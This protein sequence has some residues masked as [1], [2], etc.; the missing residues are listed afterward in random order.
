MAYIPKGYQLAFENLGASMQSN[1]YMG[2]KTLMSYD[3]SICQALC[4]AQSLCTSFNIFFE[5]DPFL[6]PAPACP[7]PISVTSIKCTLW[8]SPV[9]KEACTNTGAVREQFQVLI[10]G[11]NGASIDPL[12]PPIR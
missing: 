1:T 11:S 4:D 9:T 5:R 2:L 7:N 12:K 10:A 6:A 3:P 8:G